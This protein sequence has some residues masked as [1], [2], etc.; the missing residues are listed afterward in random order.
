MEIVKLNKESEQQQNQNT[1]YPPTQVA[2][3]RLSC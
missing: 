1:P 3:Q 2:L